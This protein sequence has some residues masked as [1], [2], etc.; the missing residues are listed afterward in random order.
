MEAILADALEASGGRI[1]RNCLV[2][3][4]AATT[5]GAHATL[6][7]GAHSSPLHARYVVGADGMHSVVRQCAGIG[8]KGGSYAESF[9]L[10]D[11]DMHWAHGHDEVMLFFAPAGLVVV[12]PL[13]GDR[14]R[15]VAT[16]DDAPGQPDINLVQTLLDTRGPVRCAATVQRLHWSSRFHIHHRIAEH[17][18]SG[19]FLL[20]GDAAHVHSPAGGQGMNLGLIDGCVLG[21]LL[22]DVLTGPR[23]AGRLD[24][25]E[26]LRR[27]DAEAVLQLSGRLT[28]VATARSA[29]ARMLRNL[30]LRAIDQLPTARRFLAMSFAGLNMA[31]AA[32]H[33]HE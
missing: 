23:D 33:T 7:S 32:E 4:L 20:A 26:T 27:P 29:P 28:R 5:E 10:A 12:A 17:Y 18:R 11:V 24:R 15:I 13:P 3:S 8:F 31:A 19:P 6:V 30:A 9:V 14:F 21:T 25:Y 1:R 2:E 22:A 16:L